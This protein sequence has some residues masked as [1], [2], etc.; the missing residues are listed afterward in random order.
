MRLS[1]VDVHLL[2]SRSR[3]VFIIHICNTNLSLQSYAPHHTPKDK[4]LEF[5]Y[6]TQSP[7]MNGVLFS[8]NT[9]AYGGSNAAWNAVSGGSVFADEETIENSFCSVRMKW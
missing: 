6:I 4:R 5:T 9:V 7:I 1:S 8:N 3:S 2:E